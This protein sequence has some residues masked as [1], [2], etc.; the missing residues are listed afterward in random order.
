MFQ[1]LKKIIILTVVCC[2]TFLFLAIGPGTYDKGLSAIINKKALLIDAF[3]PKLVLVGGSGL[4]YGI[5]SKMIETELRIKVVNLAMY[6]GCGSE[7][8]S[9]FVPHYLNEGDV[10]LFMPEY[11]QYMH[12][13]KLNDEICRK[14]AFISVFP[15]STS[16]LYDNYKQRLLDLVELASAKVKGEFFSLLN[17]IDGV[18]EIGSVDFHSDYTMNG[19]KLIGFWKAP[20]LSGKQNL[21]FDES[22]IESKK[23]ITEFN[24]KVNLKKASF[25]V[26]P[27]AAAES[28]YNEQSN[29]IHFLFS[30][31]KEVNIIG[32]P[33]DFVYKDVLFQDTV[34]HLGVIGRT[35][36][37]EKLISLF[38]DNGVFFMRQGAKYSATGR[39]TPKKY[40]FISGFQSD[41][42]FTMGDAYFHGLDY[43]IKEG[44]IYFVLTTMGW[45]PFKDDLKRLGL[46][47]L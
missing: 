26:A 27:P 17:G 36:R 25:Y 10:V 14:W 41:R 1:L 42:T 7:F 6:A 47:V 31:L 13:L 30:N 44:Q 34:N 29:A 20:E 19:N 33:E 28:W 38:K 2:S 9:H 18:R 3:S 40:D 24:N 37:T 11:G 32:S 35:L 39:I 22:I 12:K 46:R 16:F 43:H 4:A 23:I 15:S 8:Y 5:D 45:S 21:Y